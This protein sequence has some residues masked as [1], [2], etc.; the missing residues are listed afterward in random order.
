MIQ[1][2]ERPLTCAGK[3]LA[4]EE[5]EAAKPNRIAVHW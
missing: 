5:E 4:N 1:G 2:G 3:K